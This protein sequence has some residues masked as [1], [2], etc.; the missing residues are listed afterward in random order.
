MFDL[1][2]IVGGTA[3][4]PMRS[5]PTTDLLA[6]AMQ[7]ACQFQTLLWPTKSIFQ[8]TS[9]HSGKSCIAMAQNGLSA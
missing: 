9:G 1:S 7:R 5:V 8:A 4:A 2:S 3:K 6:L